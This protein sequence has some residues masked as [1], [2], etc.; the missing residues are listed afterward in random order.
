MAYI[1]KRKLKK[2]V[3]Y[4]VKFYKQGKIHKIFL[5]SGYTQRDAENVKM[6]VESFL[7]AERKLEPLDRRTRIFFETAPPDLL[8]RLGS[9]GFDIARTQLSVADVWNEFRRYEEATVKESTFIHRE[10]VFNRFQAFFSE[11]VRFS[12]L[13]PVRVQEFRDELVKRYAPTTVAKSIVDLRTFGAWAIKRGYA[14]TNPFKEVPTGKT[15]NR[16]RDFQ[17][18]ADWAPRILEACPTQNWRTLFCLW[19]FAG[20]RQQEPMLLTRESV[21]LGERKL[22]VY[23]TKTER[24][25]NGGFRTVPIVPLLAKE[26]KEQLRV[27]PKNENYLIFGNRRKAFDRGF[28]YILIQAGLPRW[29]KTFQNMRSSCENDW[30]AE[31]IPSHVVASWLGHSVKTQEKY[32]LRV[33]PEYFDRVTSKDPI[34]APDFDNTKNRGANQ[35]L[36]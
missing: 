36:F 11:D 23:A 3:S 7:N 6:A 21:D 26:L 2:G 17:V 28:Q 35:G 33:L 22:R 9:L 20:L 14:T 18:P 4:N 24:Y 19:R 8:K 30:I 25:E 31:G 5:D 13:S 15:G 16:D 12:D 27:I 34:S 32:Y 10:T 29:E 1:E